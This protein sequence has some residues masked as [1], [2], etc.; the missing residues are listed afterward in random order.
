MSFCMSK[1]T[2]ALEGF[3]FYPRYFKSGEGY[4][5]RS[6]DPW[7]GKQ[8]YSRLVFRLVGKQNVK[9]YIKTGFENIHF[10]NGS[11]VYVVGRDKNKFEA[12]FVLIEGPQ[13]E[14]VIS[15]SLLEG[16]ETLVPLE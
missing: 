11:I 5:D 2:R 13:P 9:A 16:Q 15:S 10:P 8:D 7:F 14:L 4:Y 1:D 6:Y 3:G 12:Q